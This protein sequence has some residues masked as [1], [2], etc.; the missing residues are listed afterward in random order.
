AAAA[1]RK[2]APRP[3]GAWKDRGGLAGRALA[4][5]PLLAARLELAVAVGLSRA[6]ARVRDN[7]RPARRPSRLLAN[8]PPHRPPP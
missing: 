1:L 7:P 3:P 2:L 5:H 6:A 4:A 8:P